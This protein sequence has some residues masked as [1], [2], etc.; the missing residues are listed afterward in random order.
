MIN[1]EMP[2]QVMLPV[3][4]GLLNPRLPTLYMNPQTLLQL[5]WSSWA[6]PLVQLWGGAAGRNIQFGSGGSWAQPSVQ[7]WGQLGATFSM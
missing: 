7:L 5:R 4:W 6:Q 2:A 3:T 1:D